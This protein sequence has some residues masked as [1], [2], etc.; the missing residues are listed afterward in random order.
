VEY[1]ATSLE[2]G[3]A[4]SY[5]EQMCLDRSGGGAV[6]LLHGDI[7][8]RRDAVPRHAGDFNNSIVVPY[9][10]PLVHPTPSWDGRRD[11]AMSDPKGPFLAWVVG[12]G[13]ACQR[14]L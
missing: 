10:A 5:P 6:K 13:E 8:S 3:H 12:A 2:P 7:G 1:E 11:L 14:N 9:H 4:E